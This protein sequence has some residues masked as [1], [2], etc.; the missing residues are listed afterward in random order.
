METGEKLLFEVD[1]ELSLLRDRRLQAKAW[2]ERL[3]KSFQTKTGS[4]AGTSRRAAAEGQ[5]NAAD[6]LNLWDMKMM[7]EEGATMFEDEEGEDGRRATTQVRELSKAQSVVE[8]AEEWLARMRDLINSD[9]DANG[10]IVPPVRESPIEGENG[11]DA[12]DEPEVVNL[13][14]ML[15]EMLREADGMPVQMDEVQVLRNHLQ[16]LDWAEKMRQVLPVPAALVSLVTAPAENQ[17]TELEPHSIVHTLPNAGT[18]AGMNDVNKPT[19][20]KIVELAA[21]IK[22]YF[23]LFCLNLSV[24]IHLSGYG[25]ILL[26]LRSHFTFDPFQKKC[27]ACKSCRLSIIG[28]S[29]SGVCCWYSSLFM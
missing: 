6:K 4:R 2:L 16:A 7:V 23:D 18:S 11:D 27:I 5:A 14:E 9:V 8:I 20:A 10:N 15:R 29:K 17:P 1:A 25:P 26:L 21:E 28:F 22:R 12:D 13:R 3:K 19:F 24:L